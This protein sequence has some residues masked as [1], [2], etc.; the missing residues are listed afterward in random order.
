M[1]HR[2]GMGPRRPAIHVGR[3]DRGSTTRFWTDF[4]G[5]SST[6]AATTCV[7]RRAPG[8]ARRLL[9][10]NGPGGAG[11]AQGLRFHRNLAPCTLSAVQHGKDPPLPPWSD[12][13][14]QCIAAGRQVRSHRARPCHHCRILFG[15]LTDRLSRR[16]DK[17]AR[18]T[19]RIQW[20][21]SG[22]NNYL[23]SIFKLTKGMRLATTTRWRHAGEPDPAGAGAS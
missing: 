8:P 9:A 20:R 13:Q 21:D 17:S 1:I 19:D 5:P 23:L 10:K 7:P 12:R 15:A 18:P 4:T 6:A 11:I 16:A 2:D 22:H 14:R 3:A